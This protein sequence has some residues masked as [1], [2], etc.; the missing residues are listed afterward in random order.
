MPLRRCQREIL[1]MREGKQEGRFNR[2][3]TT[4]GFQH[5]LLLACTKSYSTSYPKKTP[6]KLRLHDLIYHYSCSFTES[7]ISTNSFKFIQH[8][9]I[10][11][12]MWLSLSLLKKEKNEWN[13]FKKMLSIQMDVNERWNILL[14]IQSVCLDFSEAFF[15]PFHKGKGKKIG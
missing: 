9:C 12:V 14:L 13:F 3:D 5:H 6:Q 4:Y 11:F 15:L 10:Y 1:R 8:R 7:G 2:T